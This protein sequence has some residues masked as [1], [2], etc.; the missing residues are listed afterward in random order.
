[1]YRTHIF[2]I[3][4][5]VNYTAWDLNNHISLDVWTDW[6]MEYLTVLMCLGSKKK[7]ERKRLCFPNCSWNM[8]SWKLHGFCGKCYSLRLVRT[9]NEPRK[10]YMGFRQCQKGFII[11]SKKANIGPEPSAQNKR[12]NNIR[13]TNPYPGKLWPPNALNV[14]EMLVLPQSCSSLC[15]SV[16]FQT[17][18]LFLWLYCVIYKPRC[19]G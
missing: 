4:F 10:I 18:E 9:I 3:N 11:L 15:F 16:L 17:F 5:V 2:Q 12:R 7:N 6:T 8:K 1:M 13:P 14:L 19:R